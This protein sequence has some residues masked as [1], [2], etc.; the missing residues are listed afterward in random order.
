LGIEDVGSTINFLSMAYKD[1]LKGVGS[2]RFESYCAKGAGLDFQGNDKSTDILLPKINPDKK[3][4]LKAVLRKKL[5]A[6]I[7]L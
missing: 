2:L 5:S 3:N 1:G 7:A 4:L 6:I